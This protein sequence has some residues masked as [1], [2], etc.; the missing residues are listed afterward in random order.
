MH[1]LQGV[2]NFQRRVMT[3]VPLA[4]PGLLFGFM[5]MKVRQGPR[6]LL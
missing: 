4:A 6:M 1:T 2:K 3:N 5:V